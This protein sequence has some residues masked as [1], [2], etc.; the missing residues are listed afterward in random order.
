MAKN[1]NKFKASDLDTPY[2]LKDEE[3]FVRKITNK[4]SFVVTQNQKQFKFYGRITNEHGEVKRPLF[5][6]GENPVFK[7]PDELPKEN[8]I[9]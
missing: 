3:P 7:F 1:N 5:I 8:E 9:N 4:L 6:G 2:T